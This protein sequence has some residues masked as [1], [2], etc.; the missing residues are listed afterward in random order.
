MTTRVEERITRPTPAPP[1]RKGGD[2]SGPS[3]PNVQR[4]ESNELL[5]RMRK[6]DPDAARKYRQRSG[7]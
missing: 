6:V 2:E 4:P 3:R 7:Q 1:E 5:R